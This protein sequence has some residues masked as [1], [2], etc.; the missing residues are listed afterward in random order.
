MGIFYPLDGP[1][2]FPLTDLEPLF[3]YISRS[4][5]LLVSGALKRTPVPFA[6]ETGQDLEIKKQYVDLFLLTDCPSI[7][8]VPLFGWRKPEMRFNKVLF[9]TPDFPIR[10]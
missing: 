5:H 6:M 8:T 1:I 2:P 7:V 10:A 9:P 3:Q 4:A